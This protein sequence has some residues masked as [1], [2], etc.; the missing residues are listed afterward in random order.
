MTKTLLY[1]QKAL[2]IFKQMACSTMAE[3]MIV[4]EWSR[5]AFTSAFFMMTRTYPGLMG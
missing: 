4:M 1:I 2:A 3:R 5:Q